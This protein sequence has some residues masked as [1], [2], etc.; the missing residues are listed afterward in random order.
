MKDYRAAQEAPYALPAGF[1]LLNLSTPISFSHRPLIPVLKRMQF[2][3]LGIG[4]TTSELFNRF[5]TQFQHSDCTIYALYRTTLAKL[6]PSSSTLDQ[7]YLNT[8][9]DNY[10]SSDYLSYPGPASYQDSV[11]NKSQQVSTSNSDIS[12]EEDHTD[13]KSQILIEG[14]L[15]SPIESIVGDDQEIQSDIDEELI[16]VEKPLYTVNKEVK[17]DHTLDLNTLWSFPPAGFSTQLRVLCVY[18]C[19]ARGESSDPIFFIK[20]DTLA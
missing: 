4:L 11:I 13:N 6:E 20:F 12:S 14:L 9:L 19:I 18:V 16:I 1:S 15:T 2:S 5:P 17:L 3:T 7:L 8:D 10:S